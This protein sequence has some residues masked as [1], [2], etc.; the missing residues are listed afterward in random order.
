M[1]TSVNPKTPAIADTL[2]APAYLLRIELRN[3]KPAIYREVVVDPNISLSKLHKIIQAAMGWEDAH[4]YGFALHNGKASASYWRAPPEHKFEPPQNN[5]GFGAGFDFETSQSDRT[6]RLKDVLQAPKDKLLYMYDFGDDWEHLITLKQLVRTTEPL[7]CLIKAQNACP[8]E[9]CGGWPGFIHML[10]AFSDAQHPEHQQVREWL[11]EDFV[12]GAM[13]FA[14]LQAAVR[15]L[16][17]KARK[18]SK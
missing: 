7:P 13:D 6:T 15:R 12:P 18:A 10:E 3:L 5:E 8:P 14:E 17:P 1:P 11:G 16:V 9:D 4:L 2:G